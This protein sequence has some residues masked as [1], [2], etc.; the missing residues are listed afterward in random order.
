MEEAVLFPHDFGIFK[1]AVHRICHGHEHK[2][3]DT[4]P[5]ERVSVLWRIPGG[6]TVR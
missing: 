6:D 1:D 5:S 4:M 2:H 3:L